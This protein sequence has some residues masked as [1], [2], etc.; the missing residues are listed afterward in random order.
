MS[1]KNNFAYTQFPPHLVELEDLLRL[2][3]ERP[4]GGAVSQADDE[5]VAVVVVKGEDAA[6]D[7]VVVLRVARVAK[8]EGAV[9]LPLGGAAGA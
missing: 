5:A 9:A 3:P 4:S 7:G 6:A 2:W 8:G 1:L